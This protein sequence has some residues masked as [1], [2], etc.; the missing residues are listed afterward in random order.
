MGTMRGDGDH[1]GL[2]GPWW[3]MGAVR[4]DGEHWDDGDYE[5]LYGLWWMID[6]GH[7]DDGGHEGWWRPV[8]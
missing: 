2:Y 8:G 7:W 4:D 1:E 5:G 3:M 6:G